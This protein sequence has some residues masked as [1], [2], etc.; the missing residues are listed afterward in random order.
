MPNWCENRLTVTGPA[1]DLDALSERVII[2]DPNPDRSEHEPKHVL[3]YAALVPEPEHSQAPETVGVLPDWYEW[4]LQ[5]WGV[6]WNHPGLYTEEQ[7]P[8]AG[9]EAEL[10]LGFDTP[11]GPPL[12]FMEALAGAFPTLSYELRYEEESNDVYGV[13]TRL[14]GPAEETEEVE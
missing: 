12:P 5:H 4:R 6:K 2:D 8:Q 13:W 9:G 14:P 7:W 1:A 10:Q 3:D 11:W